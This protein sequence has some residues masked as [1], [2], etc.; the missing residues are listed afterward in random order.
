MMSPAYLP[1][2]VLHSDHANED[3]WPLYGGGVGVVIRHKAASVYQ[4]VN[5]EGTRHL[6]ATRAPHP[7][8]LPQL[9]VRIT[10]IVN[11]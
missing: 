4:R 7:T 1:R 9:Q 3:L 8:T 6:P 2:L 5:G 10:G 11:N